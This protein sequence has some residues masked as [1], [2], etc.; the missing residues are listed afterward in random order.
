MYKTDAKHL[1][2]NTSQGVRMG[3]IFFTMF[4]TLPLHPRLNLSGHISYLC[5]RWSKPKTIY[6]AINTGSVLCTSRA[7]DPLV[8]Y[9]FD[10]YTSSA[11]MFTI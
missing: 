10:I 9:T 11:R 6:C 4:F 8:V 1:T 7:R 5:W 3:G 2:N